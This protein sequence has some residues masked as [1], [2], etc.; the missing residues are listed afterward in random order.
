MDGERHVANMARNMTGDD[1]QALHHFRSNAPWSGPEICR[2]RQAESTAPPALAPGRTLIVDE[3]AEEQAGTQNAGA[4][5][6]DNGRLGKVAVCRVD[7]C[8]T[9]ANAT[10]RLWTMVDG[11]RFVPAE[12][13][14]P[15]FA[16]RRKAVGMP[17]AR[18]FE[19]QIALGVKMVKRAKAQGLP[20]ELL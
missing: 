16:Q 4:A 3:S 17:E 14:G 6:Q 12:W 1:G 8:L 9:Y 18:T 10:V 13:L 20:F 19:T 11:A 7:P 15:A 5:R 2:Q